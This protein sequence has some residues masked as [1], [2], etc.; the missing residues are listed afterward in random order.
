MNVPS[1]G[2]LEADRLEIGVRK[3]EVTRYCARRWSGDWTVSTAS[4]RT[5]TSALIA[6]WLALSGCAAHRQVLTDAQ[7]EERAAADSAQHDE[8]V[9]ASVE[10]MFQRLS[11]RAQSA[12]A[13]EPLTLNILAISGGGDYGAFGAGVL[14]GWGQKPDS[15]WRRP[16][17]D[18]VTGVSA[19]GITT[20]FA[21]IGSDETCLRIESFFRN[22][23]KDWIEE[24]GL[25]FFAP[26]NLSLL[27]IPGIELDVKTIVD[28][29]FVEQMAAQSKAGKVLVI[30]ATNLDLERRRA[31]SVG[32]EAET[33]VKTGELDR[34]HKIMLAS[35]AI[36]VAFPPV[37]IDGFLY[38][39]GGVTANLFLR[40]APRDPNS[41]IQRW[42]RAYPDKPFPRLRYWIIVNNWLTPPPKTVQPTWPAILAPTESTMVRS[43]THTEAQWLAAEADYVNSLEGFDIEIR[44][45][46]IP[47]S[48]RPPVPGDF[49]KE[50]MDSLA[51]L[52]RKMGADPASWQLWAS[53]RRPQ[54]A[55]GHPHR[56]IDR[57]RSQVPHRHRRAS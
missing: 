50:T 10:K 17:F 46:A 53:P 21:Y 18:M 15:A 19:G 54:S 26:S 47:E 20:P 22:P 27:R 45:I 5:G 33:A 6:V 32:I 1:A 8:A 48:W 9:K 41:M 35:S 30:S 31:W 25:L 34:V 40:L 42:K 4:K 16:D 29:A 36:P 37:E 44:V 57:Y 38:V 49:K 52:G 11:Q 3:E 14:V 28:R 24:R 2:R 23:R 12:S 13:S 39:D 55:Q 51:D 56:R 43:A 7:L